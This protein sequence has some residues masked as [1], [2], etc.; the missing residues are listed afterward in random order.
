MP[1]VE[2]LTVS[3]G[4]AAARAIAQ[5]W[6][7][8]GAL[9]MGASAE[10]AALIRTKVPGF[11]EQRRTSSFFDRVAEEVAQRLEPFFQVEFSRLPS[12][13]R[14]AA[15]R[16]VSRTVS[17]S[18]LDIGL[19]VTQNLEPLALEAHFRSQAPDA[20]RREHLSTDG[21]ALYDITLREVSN[22]VTE[23]ATTLP[24]F[25]AE[26][27]L[28]QLRRGDELL[29]LVRK[30][31]ERLPHSP[32]SL[33]ELGREVDRFE[34][35]YRKEVARVLDR[36]ALFGLSNL[37]AT[38]RY[39]LSVAYITLSATVETRPSRDDD[40]H[41]VEAVKS[42]SN[43]EADPS[44]EEYVRVDHALVGSRRMLI[45]GEAGSGKTTLLQ[46]LAVTSARREFFGP[47]EDLNDS[48]PFFLQLRRYVGQSLPTP[49]QF[50]EHA[51][52]ALAGIAPHGWVESLL[53]DGRALVLIDGVDELPGP[54]R[55]AAREWLTGLCSVFPGARYVVTSRPPAVGPHWL[56]SQA[57]GNTELQ[58]MD[59]GDIDSFIHHWYEA[60]RLEEADEDERAEIERLRGKLIGEVR[61]RPAIRALATS[62]LLCAVLCTL[63]RSRRAQ[64]PRDRIELYSFALAML[65]E[66]RDI[67]REVQAEAVDLTLRQKE[68]LVRE[69]AYWL[70]INDQSDVLR[71]TAV[72]IVGRIAKGLPD[73]GVSSAVLFEHLLG[74]SG[75]LREPVA[76][77]ID[78]I[79]RTFQ[80]F[81]AA[82]QALELDH[83]GVLVGHAQE[84]EWREVIVL[85][86]GLARESQRNRLLR[87]LLDAGYD[88]A[89]SRHRLHLLAVACLETAPAL[90]EELRQEI[91]QCLETLV[92][93]TTMTDA[94]A[95]ASAGDLAVPLVKS[96]ATD[97]VT[98]AAPCVRTLAWV[99]SE[100]ALD[101]LREFG[102]DTR[103]TVIKELV[104]A[105]SYF[106]PESFAE[107]VLADSPLMNGTLTLE[108]TRFVSAVSYLRRLKHLE[109]NLMGDE[110][111]LDAVASI[112]PL[113]AL[114]LSRNRSLGNLDALSG[115]PN[116]RSVTLYRCSGLIDIAALSS[117]NIEHY[118]Q[119]SSTP[120]HDLSPL[121]AASSLR[122]LSLSGRHAAIPDE[123]WEMGE[124]QT[125]T[126]ARVAVPHSI[127]LRGLPSLRRVAA[128]HCPPLGRLADFPTQVRVVRL[129]GSLIEDIDFITNVTELEHL[130]ISRTRV[131]DLGPLADAGKLRS[132]ITIGC[133][134]INDLAPLAN[135]AHL[136]RLDLE[137][138]SGV[139]DLAPLAR[140]QRLT[141]IDVSGTGVTDLS[142]LESCR[143]LKTVRVAGVPIEAVERLRAARSDIWV[144]G[145]DPGDW[146]YD[147]VP[148]F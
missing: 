25:G 132:L 21:E 81:L 54:Q 134:G 10:L 48:V 127:S 44:E 141:W 9:A 30:V 109:L 138:C 101:A 3:V 88:G 105:W 126:L 80:E 11:L 32:S 107:Q 66:R 144:W 19:L 72:E 87:G 142:P 8:E 39:N 15:I 103:L 147:E 128:I 59:M 100:A 143:G 42:G 60:A 114:T 4:A 1:L 86:S 121:E 133:S 40:P 46:W 91:G 148:P 28:E 16:A 31:L 56:A 113:S 146:S 120:V 115:H 99:G 76:G 20:A 94:R 102:S 82:Q 70:L 117:T 73:L 139:S 111:D 57:F 131:S 78:F 27:T 63:N 45:R 61:R 124:L 52:S 64:L 5:L 74:R 104:R 137:S 50:L 49:T 71:T 140:L 135:C 110:I 51:T 93:P 98:I 122:H 125:L 92:P 47:L 26:S 17:E 83:I 90:P 6:L 22:Y 119:D 123:L 53:E 145:T 36:L 136:T 38:Q 65:L 24:P 29:A 18:R 41:G 55:E 130:S 12:N 14:E 33:A 68:L 35:Q 77:R 58:P 95:L 118:S 129:T 106:E 23:I 67:E 79:H 2:T 37:E 112:G 13:E 89:T 97:R 43:P 75:L 62:P 116:L 84:D 34:D 108:S 7:G 96:H 85:A 69:L